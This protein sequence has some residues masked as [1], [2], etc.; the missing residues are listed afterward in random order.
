M[1]HSW[2]SVHFIFDMVVPSQPGLLAAVRICA[3][4]ATLIVELI[5]VAF[6]ERYKLGRRTRI[7]D[8]LHTDQFTS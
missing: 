5:L 6:L 3:N 2:V 1:A 4:A 7:S 8:E